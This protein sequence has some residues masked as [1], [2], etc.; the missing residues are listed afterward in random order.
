MYALLATTSS[1]PAANSSAVPPALGEDIRREMS[2]WNIGGIAVTLVDDQ[3]VVYAAGFGE[4]KRDSLFR[5]GS[6]SKLSGRL[7]PIAYRP[8]YRAGRGSA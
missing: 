3:R 8:F 5:V 4:A 6:I 2:D 7:M 1:S